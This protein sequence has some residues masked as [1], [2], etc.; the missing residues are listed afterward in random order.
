MI[1]V[2]LRAG[3]GRDA[4]GVVAEK[5]I[6]KVKGREKGEREKVKTGE[7]GKEKQEWAQRRSYHH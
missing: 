3:A 1:P 2:L 5:P 7:E 6:V 4:A